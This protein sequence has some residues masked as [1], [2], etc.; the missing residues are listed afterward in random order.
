MGFGFNLFGFPLLVVATVALLIYATRKKTALKVLAAIWTITIVLFVVGAVADHFRTPIMLT[1]QDVVGEYRI[2]TTFYTGKN[3]RWQYSRYKFRITESDSIYFAIMNEGR[4]C[5]T[6]GHKIIAES[7][8]P[9]LWSVIADSTCHVISGK[10]ILFRGHNKF[11]YVFH[12]S[13]FGNM[14]FRRTKLHH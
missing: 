5:K 2:D 1:K 8:P 4:S 9:F 13:K 10:P 11:Y 7:G 12:S 14:F 3:S 6:Y